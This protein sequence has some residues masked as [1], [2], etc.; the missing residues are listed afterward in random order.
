[1]LATIRE[2]YSFRHILFFDVASNNLI[3][4]TRNIFDYAV[5][6]YHFGYKNRVGY[7]HIA[8]IDALP[9]ITKRYIDIH[10]GQLKAIKR[11][12]KFFEL[13]YE[14]LVDDTFKSVA[15]IL[16]DIYEDFSH[17]FLYQAIEASSVQKVSAF[18]AKQGSAIVA[19]KDTLK[20]ANFVRSG[21][22]GE[23]IE[24]FSD[25]EKTFIEKACKKHNINPDGTFS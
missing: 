7:D 2:K 5:S 9:T 15:Y 8:P 14:D 1:M 19:V 12:Q 11:S 18:E 24:F 17:D 20:V 25:K 16:Q 6:Y 4:Q 10:K 21:K 3:I 13:S 22:V 23:G